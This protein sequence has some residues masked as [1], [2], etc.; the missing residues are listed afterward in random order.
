MFGKKKLLKDMG[1]LMRK[2]CWIGLVLSLC[3][4]SSIAQEDEVR[5]IVALENAWNQAEM[6]GDSSAL[7]L[8]LGDGFVFTDSDGTIKDKAQ[9]LNAVKHEVNRYELLGNEDQKV[10]VYGDAAIVTRRVP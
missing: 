9:W 8:L 7:D 6:K 4:F 2:L 10:H 3:A 1:S 5:H